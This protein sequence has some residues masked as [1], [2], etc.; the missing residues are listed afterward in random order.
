MSCV[1]AAKKEGP[2]DESTD[3]G[4]VNP[5]CIHQTGRLHGVKTCHVRGKRG[6]GAAAYKQDR[7]QQMRA[8]NPEQ[9]R[10]CAETGCNAN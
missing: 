2:K 8:A 9:K 7:K 10:Q 6:Q 1:K 4:G 5:G 3:Y